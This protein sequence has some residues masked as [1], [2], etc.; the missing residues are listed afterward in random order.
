MLIVLLF[1]IDGLTYH[2][3]VR[4]PMVDIFIHYFGGLIAAPYLA[5]WG[6]KFWPWFR[7]AKTWVRCVIIFCFA[8]LLGIGVEVVEYL[9]QIQGWNVIPGDHGGLSW[10][11]KKDIMA[12]TAGALAG[13]IAYLLWFWISGSRPKKGKG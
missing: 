12:D 11:T 6:D 1:F 3:H 9:D 5:M 13:T 10:E 2:F 8:I 4:T 7:D